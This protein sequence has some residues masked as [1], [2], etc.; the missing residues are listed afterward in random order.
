MVFLAARALALHLDTWH[1]VSRRVDAAAGERLAGNVRGLSAG[2]G[3]SALVAF[4]F[5]ILGAPGAYA[6]VSN[7]AGASWGEIERM[8]PA[9]HT[10]HGARR[11]VQRAGLRS[12]RA[13]A[14][15]ALWTCCEDARWES[16]GST[17]YG[18]WSVPGSAAWQPSMPIR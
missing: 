5:A 9:E 4:S 3:T 1:V 6:L 10:A 15:G 2:S 7:D 14:G 13:P 16:A 8:T 11:A 12:G 18:A 17:H